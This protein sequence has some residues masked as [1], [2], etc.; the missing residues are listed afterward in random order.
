MTEAMHSM[1]FMIL[2]KY[3]KN[4]KVINISKIPTRMVELN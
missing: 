3:F 1:G 2:K 4:I